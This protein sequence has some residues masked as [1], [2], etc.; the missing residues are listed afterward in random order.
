MPIKHKFAA[1]FSC[2]DHR[3]VREHYIERCGA[4]EQTVSR[5]AGTPTSTRGRRATPIRASRSTPTPIGL[6]QLQEPIDR[7]PCAQ[8]TSVIRLSRVA[9]ILKPCSQRHHAPEQRLMQS[10]SPRAQA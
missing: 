3:L 7:S 2:V 10:S 5:D 6:P 4:G 9:N 8:A 1:H